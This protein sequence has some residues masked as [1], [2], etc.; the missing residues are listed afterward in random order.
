MKDYF[1]IISYDGAF[2]EEDT[3]DNKPWGIQRY[4]LKA[5]SEEEIA[6][7]LQHIHDVQVSLGFSGFR[8]F[9]R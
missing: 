1:V 9:A 4:S 3:G 8:N 6:S 5:E 7:F 2:V